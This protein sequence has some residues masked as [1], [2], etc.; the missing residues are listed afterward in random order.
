MR[1][2]ADSIAH[3]IL[4]TSGSTQSK[5]PLLECVLE[6]FAL[7]QKYSMVCKEQCRVS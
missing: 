1:T 5:A 6:W 4:Y 2:I 7:L 3:S